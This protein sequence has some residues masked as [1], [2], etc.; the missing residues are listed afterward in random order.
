MRNDWQPAEDKELLDNIAAKPGKKPAVYKA[1]AK[2]HGRTEG[3]VYARYRTLTKGALPATSALS[4]D[5]ATPLSGNLFNE[6]IKHLEAI[7]GHTFTPHEVV[8]IA[9]KLKS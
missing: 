1:H 9:E 4:P 6:H 5:P 2:A 7:T 3:A 8:Q